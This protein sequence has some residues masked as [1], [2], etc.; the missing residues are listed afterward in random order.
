MQSH[1]RS[2]GETVKFRVGE[3]CDDSGCVTRPIAQHEYENYSV[4]E[5]TAIAEYDGAAAIVLANKLAAS[6]TGEAR[7]WAMHAFLLTKDPYAFY[8]ASTLAGAYPGETTDAKGNLDASAA[9]RAYVWLKVGYMLG[10]ND[11]A[12]LGTQEMILD[13]HGYLDRDKLDLIVAARVERLTSRRAELT[14][15]VF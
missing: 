15:E 7:Q 6:D 13:R 11:G 3:V 2:F 5:L 1:E 10:V 9:Q 14:G 4:E 8:M 12:D